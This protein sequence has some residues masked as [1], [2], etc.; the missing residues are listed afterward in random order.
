MRAVTTSVADKGI[1]VIQHKDFVADLIYY[2]YVL[3]LRSQYCDNRSHPRDGV[4][5]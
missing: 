3:G 4:P 2:H 5:Y 1:G